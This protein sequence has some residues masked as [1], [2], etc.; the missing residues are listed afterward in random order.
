MIRIRLEN[1]EGLPLASEIIPQQIGKF[2][3]ESRP[4]WE[5]CQ[6]LKSRTNVFFW[7]PPGGRAVEDDPALQQ[8][9]R[10]AP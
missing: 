2:P 4:L 9:A 5:S 10:R 6:H 3:E 1:F 7:K 8:A